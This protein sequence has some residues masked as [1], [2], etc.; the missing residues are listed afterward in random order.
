MRIVVRPVADPQR[1]ID[2]T[3]SLVS[4]IAEE[5]WRMHGGNQQLNWLEAER[6]LQRIVGE[7]RAEA[8]RTY[9]V[10]LAAARAS[11][12]HEPEPFAPESPDFPGWKAPIPRRRERRVTRSASGR[13]SRARELGAIDRKSVV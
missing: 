12:R 1:E 8:A 10:P 9:V 4:A 13:R 3:H 11:P 2:L 6:H 5:L 7:A